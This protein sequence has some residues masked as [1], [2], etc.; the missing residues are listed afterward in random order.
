MK[1]MR[2]AVVAGLVA[3]VL[4][5]GGLLRAQSPYDKLL[6][7]ADV[8]Q[9]TGLKGVQTTPRDPS[10]GA[11]GDLNFK[12]ADG[13]LLIATFGGSSY[14]DRAKATKGMYHGDVAGVGDAAFKGPDNLWGQTDTTIVF[15]KKQQCVSITSFFDPLTGKNKVSM[16]KL[17]A[18]AKVVAGRI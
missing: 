15:R 7:I 14:Y 6:T 11:G 16:E 3:S 18:L 12:T 9:A 1:R 4:V 5:P 8:E 2:A 10:Q 17:T 13:I